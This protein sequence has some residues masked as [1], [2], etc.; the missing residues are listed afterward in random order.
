MKRLPVYLSAALLA[1]AS[2]STLAATAVDRQETQGLQRIGSVSVTNVNGSLDDV[3]RQLSQEAKSEGARHFRVIGV[4]NP[5]D[6]SLWTGTAEI[7]R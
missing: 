5:G 4:D 3:T 6:S 2:F 7:Y 1:T